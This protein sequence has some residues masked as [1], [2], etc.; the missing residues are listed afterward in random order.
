MTVAEIDPPSVLDLRATIVAPTTRLPA[1]GA[2]YIRDGA[3]D[4]AGN[5]AAS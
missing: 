2:S 5:Q 1:P 3:Q 4:A